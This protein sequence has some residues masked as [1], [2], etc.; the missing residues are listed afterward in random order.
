[1]NIESSIMKVCGHCKVKRSTSE[2]WKNKTGLQSYC[3]DCLRTKNSEWRKSNPERSRKFSLA[4][5]SKNKEHALGKN[6]EWVAANRDRKRKTQA[7]WFRNNNVRHAGNSKR[8]RHKN[9]EKAKRSKFLQKLKCRGITEQAYQSMWE[10]QG[11][12]CA[13]CGADVPGKR[14]WHLDH[15]HI[16]GKVRG[17]LCNMCNTGLGLFRDSADN[18]LRAAAYLR[19]SRDENGNSS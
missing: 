9:P 19:R 17:I 5:Y 3:K 10:A 14:D 18:L 1:M 6:K 7:A 13:V 2:F 11:H 15:D 16:T 8:W 12:V 4:W